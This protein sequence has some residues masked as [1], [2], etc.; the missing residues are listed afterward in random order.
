M[1]KSG[2]GGLA[3]RVKIFVHMAVPT[4]NSKPSRRH[5]E[6]VQRAAADVDRLPDDVGIGA[7]HVSPRLIAQDGV[8][9]VLAGLEMHGPCATAR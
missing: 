7:E 6:D 3:V 5:A 4:G 2:S 1:L 9:E 8:P